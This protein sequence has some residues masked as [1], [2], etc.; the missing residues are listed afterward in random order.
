MYI[1]FTKIK[2]I[3]NACLR[4]KTTPEK[5][6]RKIKQALNLDSILEL[7]RT[8][9]NIDRVIW[10]RDNNYTLMS[11]KDKVQLA[12]MRIF[13]EKNKY[14]DYTKSYKS[15]FIATIKANVRKRQDGRELF[16]FAK[17]L[18]KRTKGCDGRLTL[19]AHDLHHPPF[20][21]YRMQGMDSLDKERIKIID[22]CIANSHPLPREAKNWKMEMFLTQPQ[23]NNNIN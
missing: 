13:T 9:K 1:G 6:I 21:F 19:V 15:L 10:Q 17:L 18:S 20:K 23:V 11:L 16:N 14:Y 4:K 8:P 7:Q 2:N 12:Y 22:Y 3:Y 5:K